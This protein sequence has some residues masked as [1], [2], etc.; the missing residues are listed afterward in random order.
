MIPG[1]PYSVV[2]ALQTG[3]SSWTAVLDAIRPGPTDDAT[4]VTP[5]SCAR[6]W[7]GC[8]RPGTGGAGY[9]DIWIVLDSGYDVARLTF[10]LA[11]LPVQLI[12]RLRSDR[13][14]ARP[15]AP[16]RPGARGRPPRHG[17]ALVA[18]ADPLTWP[19]TWPTPE[20]TS[21]TETTRH[22]LRRPPPPGIDATR[23]GATAAPGSTTTASCR[24]SKAQGVSPSVPISAPLGS[25]GN[26]QSVNLIPARGPRWGRRG[27]R[28]P[29]QDPPPRVDRA[30]PCS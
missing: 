24:S 1:W 19:I 15:V 28:P 29:S 17:P 30:N 18:L 10:L 20:H 11:D 2:A 4:T 27:H 14:L 26:E 12:G 23:A 3:R 8:V 25:L 16:P 5:P 21:T 6:S 7:T 9:P 22:A 13:V